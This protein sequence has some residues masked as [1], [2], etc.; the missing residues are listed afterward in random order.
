M[1]SVTTR[2]SVPGLTCVAMATDAPVLRRSVWLA[3]GEAGGAVLT[4][5]REDPTGVVHILAELS[6]PPRGAET[7]GDR[8]NRLNNFAEVLLTHTRTIA[9]VKRS[10]LR[11]SHPL[12]SYLR[13]HSMQM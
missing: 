9:L 10:L 8:R 13:H 7:L 5:V 4:A 12:D 2:K 6:G 3:G 1:E 11:A